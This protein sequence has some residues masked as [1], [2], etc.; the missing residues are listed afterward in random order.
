MAELNLPDLPI[1]Y[2]DT[3]GMEQRPL[4]TPTQFVDDECDLSTEG[5]NAL[6]GGAAAAASASDYPRATLLTDSGALESTLQDDAEFFVILVGR[7]LPTNTVTFEKALE[8]LFAPFF[9]GRAKKAMVICDLP[10]CVATRRACIP[11]S[12]L[13][14]NTSDPEK[15]EAVIGLCCIHLKSHQ[16]NQPHKE[17]EASVHYKRRYVRTREGSLHHRDRTVTVSGMEK[18]NQICCCAYDLCCAVGCR[19]I[20]SRNRFG[21]NSNNKWFQPPCFRLHQYLMSQMNNAPTCQLVCN[22]KCNKTQLWK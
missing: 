17:Y 22:I 16:R 19:G 6:G 3:N 11:W 10:N 4:Q 8:L 14:D 12:K 7:C 13:Y 9:A 18:L 2:V 20:R 15:Q 5:Y 1:A 21:I